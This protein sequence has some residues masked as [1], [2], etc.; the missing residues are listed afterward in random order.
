MR[1]QRPTKGSAKPHFASETRS[2]SS[3][4]IPCWEST[5]SIRRSCA[6]A[7]R[8]VLRRAVASW[9]RTGRSTD[10]KNRSNRLAPSLRCPGSAVR[11]HQYWSCDLRYI[12]DH[13]LPD[14]RP[15]YVITIFENFSRSILSSTISATQNQWDYLAVLIDAIR[16]YGAPE[17]IVTDGGGIFYSTVALRL[18]D[19]LGIRKERI[20]PGE[21]WQNYAETLLY[22]MWNLENS[23]HNLHYVDLTLDS[24]DLFKS[25]EWQF[26]II[27]IQKRLAD[28]AFS[29]A[30]TWPE[31]QQVHQTWWKNYNS[32]HHYAHR[33]RQDG[34]HSPAEVLRGA[35]GRT[36]PEE[37]LSRVLYATQFTRHLDR[38]GY[39]KFKH[40]RFFGENGLAGEEVSVWVYEDTLKVEHQA[41]TLSL[42]SVR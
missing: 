24:S 12:E 13:L 19:M 11:R 8:S 38:H 28:H 1:S 18:Y 31:I 37:V 39:L 36:Y 20:D 35:L 5:G 21:P 7:S 32:E 9:Q 26:H 16:R 14:P 3:R 6:W 10:W 2:A 30:R 42:Y 41:T 4:R 40:W 15:V 25:N 17:A 27:S 22:V 34:R 29:H 23:L 33:E